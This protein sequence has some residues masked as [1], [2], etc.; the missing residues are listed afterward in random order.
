MDWN[1][2]AAYQ[3][4]RDKLVRANF[5]QNSE[6][7]DGSLLLLTRHIETMAPLFKKSPEDM[8]SEL[9]VNLVSELSEISSNPKGQRYFQLI[10]R[11]SNLISHRQYSI[12]SMLK[13]QGHD[14][15]MI[16]ENTG[17]VWCNADFAFKGFIF[18]PLSLNVEATKKLAAQPFGK[19]LMITELLNEHPLF[20]AYPKLK[21]ISISFELLSGHEGS[22]NKDFQCITFNLNSIRNLLEQ[23]DVA[24]EN[25]MLDIVSHELAH[26]VQYQ[27]NEWSVGNSVKR[28]SDS[29]IEDSISIHE[30]RILKA[31]P[32]SKEEAEFESYLDELGAKYSLEDKY[33]AWCDE[34]VSNDE[35]QRLEDLSST[36]LDDIATSKEMAISNLYRI[37]DEA[38]FIK[39]KGGAASRPEFWY[40]AT[41]GEIYAHFASRAQ[42]AL[43]SDDKFS[44]SA[45]LTSFMKQVR[46]DTPHIHRGP[47]S[48]ATEHDKAK[49][50]LGFIDFYNGSQAAI[51][52]IQGHSN[53]MTWV[54]EAL[55]HYVFENLSRAA[56][57]PDAPRWISEAM[58]ELDRSF[59]RRVTD[60]TARHEMFSDAV[61]EYL[62][63]PGVHQAPKVKA[64]SNLIRDEI[65]SV[66]DY[67]QEY[68]HDKLMFDAEQ[69]LTLQEV[70]GKLTRSRR[71]DF[72]SDLYM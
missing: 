42:H 10:G 59:F 45:F 67:E 5:A 26:H 39:N 64:F 55:G 37:K 57:L 41:T 38:E 61:E 63:R 18:Q 31:F 68:G 21:N 54:H 44:K 46:Q 72:E 7:I 12:A 11:H 52:L 9:S 33:D 50:S 30:K 27:E 69:K 70:F 71:E 65:A 35:M 43:N 25:Y 49:H 51:T 13:N 15:E 60:K 32:P 29:F 17:L 62:A 8:L 56:E 4:L 58:D 14:D 16:L 19:T 3:Q 66:M 1:N 6:S 28:I 36:A 53:T 47:E 22:A 23:D 34:R 20:S 40:Y 48:I 24:L 2:S